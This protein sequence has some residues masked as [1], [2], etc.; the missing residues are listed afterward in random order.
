MKKDFYK[1]LGVKKDASQKEIKSAYRK[2][3]LKHHPDRNQDDPSAEDRFKEITEAYDTLSDP[4]KKREYDHGPQEA[5][6]SGFSSS[7]FR[8]F[9]DIFGDMFGG[10]NPFNRGRNTH[11]RASNP[12]GADA[13]LQIR[14]SFL[15]AVKGCEK[16]VKVGRKEVC[17]TCSGKGVPPD[18]DVVVCSSCNGTGQGVIRQGSITFASTCRACGGNGKSYSK[19]CGTCEGRRLVSKE[20][21]VTVKVPAGVHNGNTLKLH[22]RGHED[23]GG[24]GDLYLTLKVD[25]HPDLKREGDNIKS[26]VSINLTQAVL[27]DSVKVETVDG[28]KSVDVPAGTQP[29]DIL[30]LSGLGTNNIK[31][32]RAGDHFITIRVRI[33]SNLSEAQK[34]IFAKLKEEGV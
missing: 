20:S 31:T 18:A 3:A 32:S 10:F 8:G 14:I 1:V 34:S 24:T 28:A 23:I 4:E 9:E 21:K 15:D 5:N 6:F 11:Q 27:G 17:G 25:E 16:V 29:G 19:I 2:L 30:R 12:V 13:R 33:P 22:G 7:N 26:S